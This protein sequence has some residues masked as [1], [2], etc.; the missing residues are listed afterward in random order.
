MKPSYSTDTVT[1]LGTPNPTQM[2][3]GGV[4]RREMASGGRGPGAPPWY[5]FKRL[6]MSSEVRSSQ[7][8]W[9]PKWKIDWTVSD[10]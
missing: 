7:G 1:P 9:G 6:L 4:T 3:D 2:G 5:G 8:W 10:S